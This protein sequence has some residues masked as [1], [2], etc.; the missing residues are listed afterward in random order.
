MSTAPIKVHKIKT[1]A[2]LLHLVTMDNFDALAA[3]VRGLL[4]NAAATKA[5]AEV[6]KPGASAGMF[7]GAVIDWKDDGI[8]QQRITAEYGKDKALE[9]VTTGLKNK[10]KH[11]R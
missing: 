5:M 9:F 3:D 1:V 7:K 10:G 4:V 8:N 6:V 11:K 2:D